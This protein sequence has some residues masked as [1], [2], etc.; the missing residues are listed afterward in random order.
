M[1]EKNVLIERTLAFAIRIVNGYKYLIDNK[2]EFVMSKQMLRCGTSI[3]ANSNEAI[4]AQSKA[5]FVSKLSIALKEASETSYWLTL[6]YKTSY[7]EEDMYTS[8]KKDLDEIIR[9]IVK[10]IKTTRKNECSED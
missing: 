6:L 2:K 10:T 4:Y 7:I 5:D 3:G 1:V 9:I 8:M